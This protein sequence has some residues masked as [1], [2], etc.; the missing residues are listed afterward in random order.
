M[1]MAV[2]KSKSSGRKLGTLEDV[3]DRAKKVG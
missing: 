1:I 3:G 2:I